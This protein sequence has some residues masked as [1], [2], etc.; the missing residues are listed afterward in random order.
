MLISPAL[1]AH[2]TPA[3]GTSGGAIALSIILAA[4]VAFLL[5]YVGWK[6]WRG[7]KQKHLDA[8]K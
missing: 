8:G 7:R 5:V 2:F 3:T 6:K 1:A 4:G